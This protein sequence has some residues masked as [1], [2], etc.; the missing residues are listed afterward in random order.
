MKRIYVDYTWLGRS[1]DVKQFQA[2]LLPRDRD[3]LSPGVT[4]A[5]DGDGVLDHEATLIKFLDEHTAL[6]SFVHA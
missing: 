4:V 1:E 5:I 3:G 2:R 6:F